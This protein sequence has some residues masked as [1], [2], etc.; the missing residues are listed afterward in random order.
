MRQKISKEEKAEQKQ[1]KKSW[2]EMVRRLKP[3][4]AIIELPSTAQ[5]IFPPVGR[6]IIALL[7]LCSCNKEVTQPDK[8][9][10]QHQFTATASLT[11]S[12][13]TLYFDVF[14][15]NDPLNRNDSFMI[16][17]ARIMAKDIKSNPFSFSFDFNEYRCM[18]F[19]V[20]PN[21]K[22]YG[23]VRETFTGYINS[24]LNYSIITIKSNY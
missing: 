17:A 4:G 19:I 7:F 5:I 3:K 8:P 12:A 2:N 18:E 24:K 9:I 23:T 21:K 15:T 13:N 6:L 11:P 10:Q 16:W 22:L 20:T 14:V 1:G